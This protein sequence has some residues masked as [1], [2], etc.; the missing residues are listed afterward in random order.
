LT[1]IDQ[2][3]LIICI[4]LAAAYWLSLWGPDY[5][6]HWL[7]KASPMLLA[8]GTVLR[9]LAPRF[10][11]PM[12]IGFVAAAGGDV[13]LALDRSAFL[14]QALLCFLVTQIAYIIAFYGQTRPPG[15]RWKLWLPAVLYGG[16]VFWLLLPGLGDFLVPVLVYVAVLVKMVIAASLVERRP[17]LLLVGAGLFLIA[18]SL[19]GINRFVAPFPASEP[20]IVAIYTTG[21]LMILAGALKALPD[22]RGKRL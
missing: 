1:R 17:G 22:R 14:I 16:A 7:L 12:A 10:G 9:A 5:P 4:F 6:G 18:D 15:Q 3:V 20:I 11:I 13:F 8:A 2:R 21:Q 19:I